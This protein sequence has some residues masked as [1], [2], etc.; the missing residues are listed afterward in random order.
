MTHILIT[1]PGRGAGRSRV[2]ARAARRQPGR[3]E[4]RRRCAVALCQ[5][6]LSA[7]AARQPGRRRA[8]R[9]RN[10]RLGGVSPGRDG[11]RGRRR[12]GGPL[13]P[14][15]CS[16]TSSRAAT[17]TCRRC[18]T[19]WSRPGATC[20]VT[21]DA[22]ALP[23]VLAA[24][25]ARGPRRSAGGRDRRGGACAQRLDRSRARRRDAAGLLRVAAALRP[26]HLVVGEL[27]GPEAG[28][29]VLVA[30][31]GQNGV[32]LAM[33][34]PHARRG[35]RPGSARSRRPAWARPRPRRRW[36]RARSISYV[37]VVATPTAARASSR[38]ASRAASGAEVAA[39]RC[40]VAL[41]RGREARLRRAAGCRG[42][43][44]RRGSAARW[45]PR[46]AR[47]RPRWSASRRGR[48]RHALARR[49]RAAAEDA[50]FFDRF[51]RG[52]RA[53]ARRA[54][55]RA[56]PAAAGR[57]RARRGGARARRCPTATRRSCGRSTAPTC[58]TRACSSRAWAPARRACWPSSVRIARTSWCSP[59]RCRA[60]A[61][62]WT[63]RGACCATTRAPRSAR[64]RGRRSTRWLDATVAR[65]QILF[66][67]DGEYA[68]DV[69]DPA[70][71]EI[72]PTIALR[73]AER[74]LKVD[75]GAADAEHARGLALARLG[76]RRAR[77]WPPSPPRP[78]WTPHN[79]WPWFDLGRTALALGKPAARR[80]RRSGARRRRRAK[81]RPARACWPGRFARRRAAGDEASA[82]ALRAEALARDPRLVDGPVRAAASA[83]ADGE[84]EGSAEELALLEAVAP[85]TPV[86]R[87]LPVIPH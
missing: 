79:P 17:R 74:A 70:G 5:Q 43:A 1:A 61:T 31:R 64:S 20:I 36:W 82:A 18:S 67:P 71:Q 48:S 81:R 32:M 33:P 69:F 56:L 53:P 55:P 40:A 85:G 25:G 59:R 12:S 23:S 34:G 68:P 57:H 8:A 2:G 26:D 28:E 52:H 78:S 86:P 24:F 44:C 13:C 41:Q 42:A 49:R 9:R 19:R 16:S 54:D 72:V 75:P 84:E 10:A 76:R 21:G 30:T 39:R 37:H 51:R 29:L 47:C 58:F 66:G 60:I 87:R 4:R 7:A 80:C 83:A 46:A 45:R 14:S 27:S 6:R 50:A 65:E 63:P 77:R 11:R 35:A 73:Q 22:A 15:A 62:R 3:L 38:S